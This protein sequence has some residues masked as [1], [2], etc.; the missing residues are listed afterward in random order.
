MDAVAE[1]VES[2]LRD[3]HK[4]LY[5]GAE[6]LPAALLDTLD[7]AD[8]QFEASPAPQVFLP[9][10][11]FEPSR[12]VDTMADHIAAARREGWTG[13]RVLG[14]MAWAAVDRPGGVKRLA[15]F[16]AG[17]NRLFIDEYAMAV[18]AYNRS[19]F[20]WNDLS[21][22]CASHPGTVTPNQT[23][24]W[25]PMLR[26][27]RTA[28]PFGVAL[29][30]EADASNQRSLAAVLRALVAESNGD[31]LTI[32]ATGLRFADVSTAR[33]I[34]GAAQAAQGGVRVVGA[35]PTLEWLLSF[36]PSRPV[37]NLTVERA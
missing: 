3:E 12:M 32:D 6:L 19:H 27:R 31:S 20:S 33:Q 18:C 26:M 28:D 17:V 13:L 22:I 8:G 9:D 37:P 25:N 21:E 10:G 34:I 1:Y 29:S 23:M 16:E 11:S 7:G 2:G 36:V 4:V 30:G 15:Q 14:E 24:D 5:F 35:S